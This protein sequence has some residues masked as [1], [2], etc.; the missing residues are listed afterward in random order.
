MFSQ[1][2][3]RDHKSI[4]NMTFFC[5]LLPDGWNASD[6]FDRRIC[7]LSP[8]PSFHPL[9]PDAERK[10]LSLT[11]DHIS[12]K[13]DTAGLTAP[14]SFT[15]MSCSSLTSWALL[16]KEAQRLT[17]PWTGQTSVLLWSRWMWQH[18]QIQNVRIHL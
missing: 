10:S 18:Q 2:S 1:N 9:I 11:Q 14:G 17:T 5:P 7:N 6:R 13:Q 4:Y 3:P 12:L 16:L 8:P 15:E